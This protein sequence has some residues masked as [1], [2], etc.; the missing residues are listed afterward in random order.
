[1]KRTEI[2]AKTN[3]AE[4]VVATVCEVEQ[5]HYRVGSD[6]HYKYYDLEVETD[7]GVANCRYETST[8]AISAA[9]RVAK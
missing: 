1:M 8:E 5:S 7:H 3:D 2:F 4:T 6:S 9:K